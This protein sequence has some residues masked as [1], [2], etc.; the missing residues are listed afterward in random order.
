MKKI[1]LV[2]ALLSGGLMFTT[3][4][5]QI[6]ISLRAN[7]GEQP[8]WGPVGYDHVEYYYMPDIDAYYYVPTRQ[9]IYLERGRWRFAT[10]LP[11]R[12]SSY[13]VYTSYKVVVNERQPYRNAENYRTMYSPYKGRNNQPIIRNS[14]ESKY[15]EVKDHPEHSKWKKGNDDHNRKGDRNNRRD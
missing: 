13:N 7:I 3:A 11:R 15:F 14:Q 6:Q 2:V 9:Y 10:A 5:A 1:L 12:Y 8:V 4:S